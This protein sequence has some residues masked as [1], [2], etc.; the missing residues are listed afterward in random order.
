M[1][2]E[3]TGRPL[4]VR[5]LSDY[6]NGHKVPDDVVAAMAKIYGCPIIV[7]LHVANNPHIGGFFPEIQ[8]LQTYNDMAVLLWNATNILSEASPEILKMQGAKNAKSFG[9]TIEKIENASAMLLSIIKYAK[10]VDE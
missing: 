6:E 4:A 8:T 7:W 5:T 9:A 2:A 10:K 1:L 3:A